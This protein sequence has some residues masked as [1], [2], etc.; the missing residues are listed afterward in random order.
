MALVWPGMLFYLTTCL[1][2]IVLVY[3]RFS[4]SEI[5]VFVVMV[6]CVYLLKNSC[7]IT[8]STFWTVLINDVAALTVC[9]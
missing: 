8:L 9:M 7:C 1:D 6:S 5:V 3:A 2:S 4:F